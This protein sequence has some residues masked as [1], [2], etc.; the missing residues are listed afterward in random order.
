MAHPKSSYQNQF[1]DVKRRSIQNSTG[2]SPPN[3]DHTTH[4]SR[5]ISAPPLAADNQVNNLAYVKGADFNP[6]Q[7]YDYNILNYQPRNNATS[8]LQIAAQN[9][10]RW[11]H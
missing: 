7:K 8:S 10:I 3:Y 9:M 11:L 4:K 6:A 5:F 2:N 1:D